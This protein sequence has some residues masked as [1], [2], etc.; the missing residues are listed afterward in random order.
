[1]LSVL[2]NVK[3]QA[4]H[5]A[6]K[7]TKNALTNFNDQVVQ[8]ESEVASK[9][10]NLTRKVAA[11]E[12]KL[13]DKVGKLGTTVAQQGTNLT[14]ALTKNASTKFKDQDVQIDSKV[15]RKKG[16]NNA[17]TKFKDQDV[18]LDSKVSRKKSVYFTKKVSAK[19]RKLK[20]QVGELGC[21]GAKLR[22][23][24]LL[25]SK[26]DQV[27]E[28]A[29]VSAVQ[30]IRNTG[31][32]A[33]VTLN[34]I[35]PKEEEEEEESSDDSDVGSS[36]SPMMNRKS[37]I[38]LSLLPH[39]N[40]AESNADQGSSNGLDDGRSGNRVAGRRKGAV[41]FGLFL[42][43]QR[44]STRTCVG[45]YKYR[46]KWK[47]SKLIFRTAPIPSVRPDAVPN[48][49]FSRLIMTIGGPG[50]FQHNQ[51]IFSHISRKARVQ[52]SIG[53]V[54][55][56]FES[57]EVIIEEDTLPD[58]KDAVF[59]IFFG[60]VKVTSRGRPVATLLGN[61]SFGE[62]V[63]A[64]LSTLHL[65]TVTAVERTHV[66]IIKNS[67][68]REILTDA[69][70]D[71]MYQI[72]VDHIRTYNWNLGEQVL[73][74]L[75]LFQGTSQEFKTAL[76]KV[77]DIVVIPAEGMC[78]LHMNFIAYLCCGSMVLEINGFPQKKMEHNSVFG[79]TSFLYLGDTPCN[80][81][82]SI[83]AETDCV[84]L[85]LKY[86]DLQDT[87]A[88]FPED[89][90]IF[91]AAQ[92]QRHAS[93]ASVSLCVS[94]SS[95]FR[96]GD[97]E[98]LQ[99]VAEFCMNCSKWYSKDDRIDVLEDYICMVAS[100]SVIEAGTLEDLGRQ[101]LEVKKFEPFGVTA[102]L[103]L[104]D[105]REPEQHSNDLVSTSDNTEVAYI[106]RFAI[107]SALNQ[108]PN[109]GGILAKNVGIPMKTI[110][111]QT[112]LPFFKYLGIDTKTAV[113]ILKW[114]QGFAGQTLY[115]QGDKGDKG[116]FT[117]ILASGECEIFINRVLVSTL[118]GPCAIDEMATLGLST[119][120]R[121]S[122]ILKSTS[123]FATIHPETYR[124]LT[125]QHTSR[126]SC[127][128]YTTKLTHVMIL[129][130]RQQKRAFPFSAKDTT[131]K[132]VMDRDRGDDAHQDRDRDRERSFVDTNPANGFITQI[133]NILSSRV[134]AS[135]C[136]RF[137]DRLVQLVEF[138]VYMPSETILTTGEVATEQILI[139]SGETKSVTASSGIECKIDCGGF[140][141]ELSLVEEV[142]RKATVTA[143][144]LTVCAIFHR[145]ILV[146]LCK[147]FAQDPVKISHMLCSSEILRSHHLVE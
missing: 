24:D 19:G 17:L 121:G 101:P 56:L 125:S 75:D 103:R 21:E 115:L 6:E 106:H 114:H 105:H 77:F 36:T 55:S 5:W 109:R 64:R 50:G 141:G 132:F 123:A 65:F 140:F 43:L 91:L 126:N 29:N 46:D 27:V 60:A 112:H 33:A 137:I 25:T 18:Q 131:E 116:D 136:R 14:L 72:A 102:A 124:R 139:L 31:G 39:P 59:I 79:E 82:W 118:K 108:N 93:M 96:G 74:N 73:L 146:Q 89:A 37:L 87:A 76:A 71:V 30:K 143:K 48:R 68:I 58:H 67:V 4:T 100:G 113:N 9:G 78:M 15:A 99:N 41:D 122:A 26:S 54:E 138:R 51:K 53:N 45:S 11:Q 117:I 144:L 145:E 92:N 94:E 3:K 110:E 35:P 135:C 47:K 23:T 66:L 128:D 111:Y 130:L 120:R 7:V 57:G 127:I 81:E 38:A 8:L 98:F 62:S 86:H 80:T 1:M 97:T 34:M 84:F 142:A 83:V 2:S 147:K 70:R 85:T 16:E 90:A 12:R 40:F 95:L 63:V 88:K 32:S 44:K 42:D 119:T 28:T 22:S 49:R 13:K 107:I 61:T 69:E 10:I 52:L 133:D 134:F 104:M 129:S 20:D